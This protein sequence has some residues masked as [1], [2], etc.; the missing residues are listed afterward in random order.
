MSPTLVNI[1]AAGIGAAVTLLVA[2]LA[3]LRRAFAVRAAAM[4]VVS[5]DLGFAAGVIEAYLEQKHLWGAQYR[6]APVSWKQYRGDLASHLSEASWTDLHELTTRLEV[7]DRWAEELRDAA[8][9]PDEEF[10]ENL[11]DLAAWIP[12]ST[13]RLD[14]ALHGSRAKFRR[15][16]VV[17]IGAAAVAAIALAVTLVASSSQPEPPVTR[18]SLASALEKRVPGT[19]MAICDESAELEG[20]YVCTLT[21]S[22]CGGRLEA[23][24]GSRPSCSGVRRE[25]YGVTASQRC[26]SA[27]LNRVLTSGRPA[28]KPPGWIRRAGIKFGCLEG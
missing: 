18:A 4:Q 12:V 14:L 13:E 16:R 28:P 10:E 5:R 27:S 23:S 26:F 19:Q 22:A 15:G 20:A 1:A 6:L 17:A 3:G 25:T 8:Q 7:V 9:D 11:R 24:A 2:Y 21:S